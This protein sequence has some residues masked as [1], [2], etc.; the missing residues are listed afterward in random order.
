MEPKNLYEYYTGKKQE[1]PSLE[2]RGKLYE[3]YGLGTAT[4]Y[5]SKNKT[6]DVGPNTTL[7]AKLLAGDKTSA[8]NALSGLGEGAGAVAT[9]D[10]IDAAASKALEDKAKKEAEDAATL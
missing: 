6:G 3:S 7:L 2:E 10:G 5:V 8:S 9:S 4:D 1:L